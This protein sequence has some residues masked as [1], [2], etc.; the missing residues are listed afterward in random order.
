M[1]VEGGAIMNRLI[2]V[3][4]CICY[5][6]AFICA[7]PF[8][9]LVAAY[10]YFHDVMWKGPSREYRR[11]YRRRQVQQKFVPTQEPMVEGAWKP[12]KAAYTIAVYEDGIHCGR[13]A[14]GS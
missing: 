1:H 13:I 2:F 7:A 5:I 12:P 14:G 10:C 8:L 6:I 11:A 4:V 3:C 9:I